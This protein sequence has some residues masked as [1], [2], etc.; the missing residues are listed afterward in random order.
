MKRYKVK[1]EIADSKGKRNQSLTIK[2]GSPLEAGIRAGIRLP[3]HVK[4][5]T[6]RRR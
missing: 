2:A 3:R 5:K 4:I 6:I 1:Y